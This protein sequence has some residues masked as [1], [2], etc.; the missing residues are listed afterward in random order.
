ML[1]VSEFNFGLGF[2]SVGSYWYIYVCWILLAHLGTSEFIRAFAYFPLGVP[3]QETKT[4]PH[5]CC[6]GVVSLRE[7]RYVG[8]TSA[9]VSPAIISSSSVGMTQIVTL[10][11][12]VEIIASS[13]WMPAF[14]ASSSSAPR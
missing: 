8:Y 10:L 11:F 7:L 9:C 3:Y 5:E 2:M 6:G 13:P 4:P 1:C 14:F 12:G